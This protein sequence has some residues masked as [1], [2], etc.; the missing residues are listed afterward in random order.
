MDRNV[1]VRDGMILSGQGCGSKGRCGIRADV[2][3]RAGL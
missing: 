2:A 1:E 3:I